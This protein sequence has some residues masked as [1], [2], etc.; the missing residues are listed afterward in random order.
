MAIY[1]ALPDW[2]TAG[3]VR[4]FFYTTG[5]GRNGLVARE[6]GATGFTVET[7]QVV[8]GQRVGDGAVSEIDPRLRGVGVRGCDSMSIDAS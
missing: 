5:R 3:R 7:E 8:K 1:S 4:Y 6:L 2:S